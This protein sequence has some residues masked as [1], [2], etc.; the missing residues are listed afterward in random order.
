M[1]KTFRRIAVACAVMGGSLLGM[2]ASPARAQVG[3]TGGWSGYGPSWG[4]YAPGQ[5]WSG[6]APGT[7]WGGYAPGVPGA[8]GPTGPGMGGMVPN[9]PRA[10]APALISPGPTSTVAPSRRRTPRVIPWGV[11]RV[12]NPAPGPNPYYQAGAVRP[13][14]EYGTGRQ[15]PAFK[16]WLPGAPRGNP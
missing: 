16:P 3:S 13:Y 14:M 2:G 9:G 6:Y 4:G 8:I 11:A 12:P 7:A 15:V 1:R 10:G 5:P